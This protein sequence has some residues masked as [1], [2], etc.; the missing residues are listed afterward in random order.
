MLAIPLA[1]ITMVMSVSFLT[2][3]NISYSVAWPVLIALTVNTLVTTVS[4]FYS[5]CLLGV[6]AFDAEG[7]ISIR[8]LVRS[9]IFKVFSIPYIQAAIALPLTYFVLTR[10]PGISSVQATLYVIIILI[11]VNLSTFSGLYLFMRR[12]IR[13]LIAWKSIA[14][15]ILSALLMGTVLLLLPTTTTLLSTIAKAIAGFALYIGLLLSIDAQARGLVR[16]IWQEIT[17]TLKQLTHMANNSG[18][19]PSTA[20]EN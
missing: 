17:V 11:T 8:H 4:T 14:K 10:L 9:K 3:L 7:K 13:I 20:S 16:L 15:Y 18:E 12:S 19:T 6:E 2:V 1:T 5:N